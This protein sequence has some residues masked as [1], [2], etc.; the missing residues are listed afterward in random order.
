MRAQASLT[1]YMTLV[2]MIVFIS[3]IALLLLFGFQMFGAGSA[4]VE[5]TERMSLFVLQSFIS[6]P[7][8][9]NPWYHQGS[10]FDD[11]KLT[12]ASCD[13]IEAIFGAGIYAEIAVLG[14]ES[15]CKQR[16]IWMER[17]CIR[18]LNERIATPCTTQNYPNCGA[19]KICEGNKESRMVY[20]SIP[21]NVFRKINN[22]VQMAVLTVGLRQVIE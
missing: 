4:R 5:S 9:T 12:A 1:E 17:R 8:L 2:L 7:A 3:F 19:W 13:D 18:E 15:V 10:V 20:R 22:T 14:D 16:S 11:A 6:S 21:V